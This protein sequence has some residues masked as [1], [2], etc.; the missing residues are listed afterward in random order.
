MKKHNK[1]HTKNTLKKR[2]IS[3]TTAV[4]LLVGSIPMSIISDKIPIIGD[5]LFPPMSV[6]AATKYDDVSDYTYKN[7]SGQIVIESWQ[8]LVNYS[9][10]YYNASHGEYGEGVSHQNDEILI[11]IG[12]DAGN[13]VDLTTTALRYEPI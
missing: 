9:Q 5:S 1:T 8:D 11:A 3:F 10:A 7:A 6:S 2:L 4:A 13:D 12:D